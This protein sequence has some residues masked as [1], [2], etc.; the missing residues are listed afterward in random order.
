MATIDTATAD[1]QGRHAPAGPRV[2]IVDDDR[3]VLDSLTRVL[4]REIPL[5]TAAGG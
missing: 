3:S 5:L 4:R 2:L 1:A